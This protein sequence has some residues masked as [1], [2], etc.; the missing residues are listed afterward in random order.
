M[1][2]SSSGPARRAAAASLV[3]GLL[4][5]A[6]LAA[7]GCL[8]PFEP[9]VGTAAAVAVAP[10]RPST[11]QGVLQLFRWCWV[12]RSITEYEDL[13]TDD[14]RFAFGAADSL[15]NAPILRDDE[16]EIARNIFVD[17]S[18]TQPRA[19]RIDLDFNSSLLPIPDSRPGKMFPWHQEIT[20]RVL[21]RVETSEANYQISGDARFFLV[22]G[23]SAALPTGRGLKPD[24]GRWFIERW[25]DQTGSG[26]GVTTGGETPTAAARAGGGTPGLAAIAAASAS[27]WVGFGSGFGSVAPSPAG[28]AA[29][30]ATRLQAAPFP[31]STSWGELMAIYR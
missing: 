25:E 11:P 23:D 18:A 9:R 16:I 28:R 22:R 8:N 14:F 30:P 24:P 7:S 19:N 31:L 20:A 27:P 21:L 15:D 2:V 3:L 26:A 17:G 10:P 13:F 5:L 1:N 12:N 29:P 4:A 6:A